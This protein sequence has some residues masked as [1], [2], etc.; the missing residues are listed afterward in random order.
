MFST[1]SHFFIWLRVLFC[2][3]LIIVV[4]LR[5]CLA[6]FLKCEFSVELKPKIVQ[7]NN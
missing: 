2:E 5:K 4:N 6:K 7:H 3:D 1:I